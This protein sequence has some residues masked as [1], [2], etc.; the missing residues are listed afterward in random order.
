VVY[1]TRSHLIEGRWKKNRKVFIFSVVYKIRA[2]LLLKLE[3]E[4]ANRCCEIDC[5]G[6]KVQTEN[7]KV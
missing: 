4:G 1:G 5:V 2:I 7:E 3:L 6:G